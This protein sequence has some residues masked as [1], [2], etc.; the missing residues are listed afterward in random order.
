MLGKVLKYD[1]KAL[2]RYLIPLYAVIVGLSVM[3]R[4]LG[5]F[6]K[7]P[8]IDIVLG[9]MI[10]ALVL[11]IAF[12][13]VL[14]G[15]FNI[16]HYLDNLFKDEGY[17]TH[18]LPV[19]KGTLLLSKVLVSLITVMIT[20]ILIVVSLLVA[21]YQKG[22]FSDITDLF[23]LNLGGLEF[24][25]F[26]IYM[27]I[28]G[29]IG[30]ITTILMVFAAIAIGYSKNTNKLVSSVVWALIFYFGME[31]LYLGMLG[32]VM[33]INP[34]FI[35]S[36]EAETFLMT[37]LLNFF[38]IFMVFTI[39]IGCAFYYISYRFMDKKLNLE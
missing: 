9:L 2:N 12:S 37:D 24:Y 5:F 30:Y 11:V 3:V 22:L 17:L 10:V 39:L 20:F 33:A 21:F 28:Y 35:A 23:N 26:M 8:V 4:L 7:V 18:T 38:T 34:S 25:K 6:E 14:T 13:F 27:G 15:I 1:L 29:L 31:F 32:I 36:L 16:K 19:K